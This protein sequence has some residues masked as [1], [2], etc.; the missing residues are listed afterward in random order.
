M[1]ARCNPY[2]QGI[3]PFIRTDYVVP[4]LGVKHPDASTS[5]CL[6]VM[7]PRAGHGHQVT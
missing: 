2:A 7:N 5:V 6:P 3:F 1:V 4:F